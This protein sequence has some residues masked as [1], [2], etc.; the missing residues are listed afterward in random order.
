MDKGG[1]RR[2]AGWVLL[3][4]L[5]TFVPTMVH[6]NAEWQRVGEKVWLE[7]GKGI[8]LTTG[9]A[10]TDLL[11]DGES[12][13]APHGV[14]M[15]DARYID[16]DFVAPSSG[17]TTSLSTSRSVYSRLIVRLGDGGYAQVR[18][19][20]ASANGFIYTGLFLEEWVVQKGSGKPE[21]ILRGEVKMK[22]N[23][24]EA[25]GNGVHETLD[26]PPQLING[27]VMVP[28]RYIGDALNLKLQ[29]DAREQKVSIS[30]ELLNMTLT[31]GKQSAE[32]NG[33]AVTLAQPPTIIQNRLMIP[34]QGA[35]EAI[36]GKASYDAAT[37]A[38]TLGGSSPAATKVDP[39]ELKG[40]PAHFSATWKIGYEGGN[41]SYSELARPDF[42]LTLNEDGSARAIL[43]ITGL[44]YG[45]TVPV[46]MEFKG[47]YTRSPFR[48]VLKLQPALKG[49]ETL[50]HGMDSW[51]ELIVTGTLSADMSKIEGITISGSGAKS[52]SAIRAKR[53]PEPGAWR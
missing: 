39:A 3:A 17:Y 7:P 36:A 4:M 20:M 33:Q 9:K 14:Q 42:Y 46:N 27:Q 23:G 38:I 32:I 51:Q 52:G 21:P 5:L 41:P 13:S 25:V 22:L 15:V 18:L 40:W 1:M 53:V 37:G 49:Y 16:Y 10:G 30:G 6:A 43:T 48:A 34:L 19:G 12:I 44:S 11:F 2:L 50:E 29:W 28:L 8:N 26:V 47:T 35:G 45:A 24:H 31:V